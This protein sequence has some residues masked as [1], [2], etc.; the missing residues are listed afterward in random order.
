[1]GGPP[2]LGFAGELTNPQC[3]IQHDTTC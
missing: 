1:M 2:A 3:K